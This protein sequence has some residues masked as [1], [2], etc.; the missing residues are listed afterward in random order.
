[1]YGPLVMP[2]KSRIF[3]LIE[4]SGVLYQTHSEPTPSHHTVNKSG[5]LQVMG[6][7]LTANSIS[8][9]TENLKTQMTSETSS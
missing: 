8:M 4:T 3:K 7:T 1:M 2:G 5:R 6:S 9:H